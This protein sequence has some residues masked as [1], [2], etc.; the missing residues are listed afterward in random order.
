MPI[1]LKFIREVSLALSKRC[2]WHSE[3]DARTLANSNFQIRLWTWDPSRIIVKRRG[4]AEYRMAPAIPVW[5]EVTTVR[6]VRIE[7]PRKVMD[8]FGFANDVVDWID[9]DAQTHGIVFGF[10]LGLRLL[11]ITEDVSEFRHWCETAQSGHFIENRQS[12]LFS[13]ND[14]DYQL[15]FNEGGSERRTR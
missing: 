9:W 7:D 13:I 14:Y 12:R 3:Y 4:L 5:I 6:D 1:S 10:A 2:V 11:I 8:D 15:A